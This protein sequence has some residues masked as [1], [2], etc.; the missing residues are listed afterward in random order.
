MFTTFY[1]SYYSTD[2]ETK[3]MIVV[4]L[5][6]FARIFTSTFPC[7]IALRTEHFMFL[8]LTFVMSH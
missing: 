6:I 4:R 3:R 5:V 7:K 2:S 8:Y 1:Y